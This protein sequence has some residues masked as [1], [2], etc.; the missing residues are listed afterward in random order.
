MHYYWHLP[1][2]TDLRLCRWHA[3]SGDLQTLSA[4]LPR[5]CVEQR[6]PT[7]R[8]LCTWRRRFSLMI[9]GLSCVGSSCAEAPP[10]HNC[11]PCSWLD[12]AR[13]Q[14]LLTDWPSVATWLWLS[15]RSESSGKNCIRELWVRY[16]RGKLVVGEEFEVSLRRLSVWLYICYNYS[17]H[18]RVIIICSYDWRISS[19]STHQT[20]PTSHWNT[21]Q[22]I[23]HWLARQRNS[24]SCCLGFDLQ[25]V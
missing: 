22:Y 11:S 7:A 13:H 9:L 19:K 5:G 23:F 15:I 14:D 6:Q 4:S 12:G 18:E 16:S 2:L 25:S 20:P 1:A 3:G 8:A 24:I 10:L 17:N 21:W